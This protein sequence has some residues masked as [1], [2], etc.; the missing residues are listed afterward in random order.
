MPIDQPNA[1]ASIS[2]TLTNTGNT[3]SSEVLM[4]YFRPSKEV[5]SAM[6]QAQSSPM[7]SAGKLPLKKQLF[8]ITRLPVIAAGQSSTAAFTFSP[9]QLALVDPDNGD[10]VLV[11]GAYSLEFTTGRPDEGQTA[12]WEVALTGSRAVLGAFP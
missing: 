2:I 6:R 12:S 3:D 5:H 8:A 4:G 1:T 7:T 9:R 11:P 10:S